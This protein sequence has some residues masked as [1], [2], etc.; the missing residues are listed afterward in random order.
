MLQVGLFSIFE[1]TITHYF[2]LII[3]KSFLS[4]SL[5]TASKSCCNF[6]SLS[7]VCAVSSAYLKLLRFTPPILIP[8]NSF[9]HRI[10]IFVYKKIWRQNTPVSHTPHD[11]HIFTHKAIYSYGSFCWSQYRFFINIMSLP[12]K[13]SDSNISNRAS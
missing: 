10:I 2:F 6:F 9:V 13:S 7:A 1:N 3:S 12:S 5:T 11:F 4:L 8:S